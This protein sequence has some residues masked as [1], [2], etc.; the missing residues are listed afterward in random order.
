M[1][2]A[3]QGDVVDGLAGVAVEL[4]QGLDY[5]APG[6]GQTPFSRSA[7]QGLFNRS[8]FGCQAGQR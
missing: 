4:V 5:M 8:R 1:M 3:A 2:R 7:A 6:K